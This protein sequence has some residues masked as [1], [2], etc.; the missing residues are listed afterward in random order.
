MPSKMN[1]LYGVPMF[2]GCC[3]ILWIYLDRFKKAPKPRGNHKKKIFISGDGWLAVFELLTPSQL[4]LGIA[5]IS[6]RFDFYVDEH[7]KTRRWAFKFK[8]IWSKKKW[9]G[10]KEMELFNYGCNGWEL[11]EIPQKALPKKVV[12]FEAISIRYIDRNVI[13]FLHRFRPLFAISP[14]NLN[15]YTYNERIM[16]FFL[17]IIWPMLGKN[18]HGI[19]LSA[20]FFR[21]LR[22]FVPSLFNDF[23][24]LRILKFYATNFFTEFPY[25]DDNADASDGQALAK[26][27]FTAHP[28]NLP[29]VLRCSLYMDEEILALQ[30]EDFKAAFASASSPANFIAVVWFHRSPF[31]D[32]VVPFDL[33]NELTEEQLALKITPDN[34]DCFV[35][36]RCPIARDERKWAKWE[37]EAIGWRNYVPWSQIDIDIFREEEIGDGLLDEILGPNAGNDAEKPK[38]PKVTEKV[39]FDIK[40]GDENVGRIEIGLFGKTVPKTVENFVELAKKPKGEG[41]AGSVFHRVIKDFMIQGG[42]FTKGDGT[43]GKSIWGEKFP[44]ENFK[45]KHYGAGWLSMA[46]SG[47]DTNG[48]QFFITCKKTTWLDGRHVVFGKV[49]SGMS[50]VRRIEATKTLGGDRPEKEV[51]IAAAG[52]IPVETP[53]SVQKEDSRDEL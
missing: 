5:M 8:E 48:S 15:I 51:T 16:E 23:P 19:E 14:I 12:G 41:Y 22:Q 39:Y 31:D 36:V 52:Q 32:F 44:D 29:K 34:S 6:H 38:G 1:L 35:F 4:G 53:F 47:K 49:L 25:D 13:A 9:Y 42:D 10:A 33:T 40:I 24:L 26:W 7:F 28:N 20:T 37:K 45:L 17:R 11:L 3:A 43:G 18:I 21:L 27:L 50:V 2:V 46:N 30:I